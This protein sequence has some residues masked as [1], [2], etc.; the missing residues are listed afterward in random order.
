MYLLS[1]WSVLAHLLPLSLFPSFWFTWRGSHYLRK[2]SGWG[3]PTAVAPSI[4]LLVLWVLTCAFP[5]SK[6]CSVL[7]VELICP[8]RHSCDTWDLNRCPRRQYIQ[9]PRS[10]FLHV[11]VLHDSTKRTLPNGAISSEEVV[12]W[13]IPDL[14]QHAQLSP[15]PGPMLAFL[16]RGWK[17]G[18]YMSRGS[19]ST[20]SLTIW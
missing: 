8:P 18:E 20:I 16:Q 13:K 6:T 2:G 12:G 17:S 3:A 19:Q 7:C 15:D 14:H 11:S 1:P 4:Q 9:L 10:R 5:L